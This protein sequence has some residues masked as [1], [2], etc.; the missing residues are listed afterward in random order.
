[1]DRRLAAILAM[2]MVGFSRLMEEDEE[3]ILHRQKA[4]LDEL[5]LPSI[6]AHRGRVVKTTGDGLLAE[7]PSAVDAVV[8]AAKIQREMPG[9]EIQ[10]PEDRRIQFRIGIHV[11]D[12]VFVDGDFFGDGVN[13]AARIEPLADSG[14]I[15]VSEGVFK[16]VKNKAEVGFQDVGIQDL[17]N[18]SEPVR[19]FRVLLDAESAGKVSTGRLKKSVPFWRQP[20]YIAAAAVIVIMGGGLLLRDIVLVFPTEGGAG[21][22][23]LGQLGEAGDPRTIAVLYLEDETP[24]GELEFVA[25]GLTEALIDELSRVSSLR[26]L[27]RNA[28]LPFKDSTLRRDSI[29]KLLGAGTV[30]SGSVDEDGDQ[31]RVDVALSEGVSGEVFRRGSFS[32]PRESI[33]NLQSDLATEVSELLRLW[34]GQEVELRRMGLETENAAAWALMQR[35]EGARKSG[36]RALGAGDMDGLMAA[37]SRADSLL[38]AA[39][40]L[41]SDWARPTVMRAQLS[42]RRAQLA[43]SH[44]LEAADWIEEGFEHV[45]RAL[46]RDGLS[47]LGLETRGLL[48]YLS[49]ALSIAPDPARSARFLTQAEQDLEAAVSLQPSLANAWN[50]LSV[51]HSQKPDLIEAKIAAQRAY[52]EDAFLRAA[53]SILWRLYATSYDL[54]QF[55]DAVQYCEEGRRRFPNSPGFYECE[56]WLLATRALEPDVDRAWE[57]LNKMNELGPPE[58]GEFKALT[59]RIVVGGVLA[60]AGLPDSA[61]AV[62]LAS[63]GDPEVDPARE[64]LGYEAVFRLQNG[65][66]EEA[67]RLVKTYLTA[68]PEHRA[69]WRW[70]SH[71]WWRGL[72]D[73]PEFQML[74]GS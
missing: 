63:R 50:I 72:Q 47:P 28:S 2:D 49:W 44:P 21:A 23:A 5:I 70:T 58:G 73:N 56:L 57:L 13:I 64:L 25:D 18:I 22:G 69:G 43:A 36:E 30:V 41:D 52:E 42:L 45:D 65:Q 16:A 67:M 12:I 9:R 38:A 32:Q 17:K 53:E 3:G 6:S 26:V 60:R 10:I 40:E 33:L 31:V 68:S 54:E 20:A 4:H 8:C 59:G 19:V 71:W 66:E 55:P 74:M 34:L 51:V 27:S 24:G 37:F 46:A 48:A 29:A 39:E 1:M 61:N 11:G 35:G 62:W 14:G 15:C 7:F